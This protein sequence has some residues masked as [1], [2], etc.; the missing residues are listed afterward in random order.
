MRNSV[1]YGI[2]I[3]GAFL[4][5]VVINAAFPSFAEAVVTTFQFKTLNCN[6]CTLTNGTTTITLT[7]QTGTYNK[8]LANNVVVNSNGNRINFINGTGTPVNVKNDPTRNQVNIT[9]AQ[10]SVSTRTI[11]LSTAGVYTTT[12]DNDTA[13][14]ALNANSEPASPQFVQTISSGNIPTDTTDVQDYT[15][16]LTV[17]G[18]NTNAT[19]AKTIS[20]IPTRNGVDVGSTVSVA[21][22]N[23]NFWETVSYFSSQSLVAGDKLGLKMWCST[24]SCSASGGGLDYRYATLYIIPRNIN[25]NSICEIIGGTTTLSLSGAIA[26][27]TYGS[28]PGSQANNVGVVTDSTLSGPV[29]L[30]T[31]GIVIKGQTF[32]VFSNVLRMNTDVSATPAQQAGSDLMTL[33]F[34]KFLRFNTIS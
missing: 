22:T 12:L 3:I 16:V 26:G 2:I 5:L 4:S 15:V 31:T 20:T 29:V 28:T 27:V 7:T 10:V 1:L 8:T 19:T 23:G 6:G 13:D 32:S 17:G 11:D 18:K 25:C 34:Q 33:T 21:V 30:P 9:L 14:T 24:A